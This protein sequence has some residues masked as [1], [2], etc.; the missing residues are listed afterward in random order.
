MASAYM[1]SHY[2]PGDGQVNETPAADPAQYPAW[3]GAILGLL[4][5]IC[6]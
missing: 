1:F 4:L 2:W 6:V 3:Q 5:L